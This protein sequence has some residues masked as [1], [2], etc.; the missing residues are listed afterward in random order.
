MKFVKVSRMEPR[1]IICLVDEPQPTTCMPRK[2]F[3]KEVSTICLYN[4][5]RRRLYLPSNTD[6]PLKK[7]NTH[8]A[9]YC[10]HMQGNNDVIYFYSR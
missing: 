4:V 5:K 2:S 7:T 9:I 10:T 1:A 3:H 6:R 8:A